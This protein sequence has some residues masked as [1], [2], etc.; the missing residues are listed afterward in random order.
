MNLIY[1]ISTKYSSGLILLKLPTY[2]RPSVT[3]NIIAG[4][5]E[6]S[7]HTCLYQLC[8][9]AR[10]VPNKKYTHKYI[11]NTPTRTFTR[12]PKPIGHGPRWNTL[13]TT[14]RH[15]TA[16]SRVGTRMRARVPPSRLN[17]ASSPQAPRPRK[18]APG[19]LLSGPHHCPPTPPPGVL[20]P[21]V[22]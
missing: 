7:G 12:R 2:P 19:V 22:P 9:H 20:G 18:P 4:A 21:N 1:D 5:L 8:Q 10:H 16:S 11:T 6:T 13:L 14:S 17:G 15:C 3:I